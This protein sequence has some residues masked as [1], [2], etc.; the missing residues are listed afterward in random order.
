MTEA[1]VWLIVWAV[2]AFVVAWAII[3][4]LSIAGVGLA[5]ATER[6]WPAPVLAV[7]GYLAGIGWFIFAAVHVGLQIASIVGIATAG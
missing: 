1:I 4:L 5:A 3:A 7:I 2:L 6:V